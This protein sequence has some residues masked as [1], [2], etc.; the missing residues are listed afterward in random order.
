MEFAADAVRIS[1]FLWRKDLT[2]AKNAKAAK[3]RK[4]LSLANL[5]ALGGNNRVSQQELTR[6]AQTVTN[7]GFGDNIAGTR[8]IGFHFAAQVAD[9]NAQ[10][11]EFTAVIRPPNF[12]K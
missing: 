11:V 2:T 9:V 8:R 5:C 1:Y 12:M 10:H 3:V 4:G 7:P 6:C